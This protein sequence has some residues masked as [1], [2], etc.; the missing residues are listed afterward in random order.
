[1]ENNDSKL[2]R[3]PQLGGEG[4]EA[5]HD[6]F[7]YSA[8][9]K[10]ATPQ[11]LA[12]IPEPRA[13]QKKNRL[14]E[15]KSDEI[16]ILKYLA[17][18]LRRKKLIA[19]TVLAFIFLS[20]IKDVGTVD[21]YQADTK[22]LVQLQKENPIGQFDPG[23][24]WDRQTKINT[25]LNTI[26]S[27]EVL[28]RVLDSAYLSMS[29][30]SLAGSISVS[31]LEETNIIVIGATSPDPAQAARIANCAARQFIGYNNEINRKDISDAIE[32][33]E[34]QIAKTSADLKAKE[35]REPQ[36]IPGNKQIY[37]GFHGQR[38]GNGVAVIDGDRAA[39]RVC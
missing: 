22:L 1:M 7:D 35:R 32:Y 31:K 26:K 30:G 12:A 16:D 23:Y 8:E 11:T 33:I 14:T 15:K 38:H 20:F 5:I 2:P 28:Q 17:V 24:F 6:D 19:V 37:R 29:L 13:P 3:Q 9:R 10:Q 34:N 21:M 4:P 27:R 39:E 36:G 25:M 18:L